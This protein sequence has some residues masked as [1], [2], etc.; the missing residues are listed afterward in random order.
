MYRF[1]PSVCLSSILLL[2]SAKLS[3]VVAFSPPVFNTQSAYGLEKEVSKPVKPLTFQYTH[4]EVNG[5]LWQ[6]PEAQVSLV[7]DPIASQLD[8]GIP[9]GYRAN[10]K[11]LGEKET[12]DVIVEAAPTH[13]LLSQGL[14]D[15]THL[16]TL[17]KLVEKLPELQFIVAPSARDKIVTIVE[18]SRITVLEPGKSLSLSP[19]V[20]LAATEGA[21]VGPPWQARENGWLLE[22]QD[23]RIYMEPHADVTNQ[24]LRGLKADVVISP[25]KEQTLP[26]QVPKPGQFTLVYGG[27]RTLEIAEALD[28][29]VVIPLANGELKTEGPLAE[30]VQASGG[31]E[32]FEQLVKEA[33]ER[34]KDGSG[35]R[36]ERS[37][38]GVPLKVQL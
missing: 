19:S 16:P 37:T 21:L 29:S 8:F 32:D 22:V 25:V 30:L 3:A 28:A 1:L 31:V 9:W 36:V 10:K 26:A 35:I 14:D 5:M 24:A 4:L 15:H 33:N 20:R 12:F 27:G 11:V 34:R 13:C 17:I 2:V 7:V 38:P 23:R 18:S 6:V